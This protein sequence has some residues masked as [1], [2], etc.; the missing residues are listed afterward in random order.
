MGFQG[1]TLKR[2]YNLR[3]VQKIEKIH[4]LIGDLKTEKKL[5]DLQD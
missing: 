2:N 5:G 1:K 3:K 4:C